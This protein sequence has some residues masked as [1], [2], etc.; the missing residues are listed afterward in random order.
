MKSS[1]KLGIAIFCAIA[2]LSFSFYPGSVQ[3]EGGGEPEAPSIFEHTMSSD[4]WNNHDGTYT[5]TLYSGPMNYESEQ[6][7]VPINTTVTQLEEL[8]F[9]ET[10]YFN[11]D[12][13]IYKAYFKEKSGSTAPNTKPVR[14]VYE[15]YTI[16]FAP[17]S[18]KFEGQ[19]SS[20]L[21][22]SLGEIGED[23]QVVYPSQFDT[24]IDL[25]YRYWN[26][27]LKEQLVINS[28]QDIYNN[29]KSDPNPEDNLILKFIIRAYDLSDD[30]DM[31]MRIGNNH[32]DFT[33]DYTTTDQ[34]AINFLDKNNRTIYRM[35]IPYAIDADGNELL[36]DYNIDI[37]RF[38]NLKVSILTPFSWLENAVYPVV[39]DPTVK[40]QDADTENLEDASVFSDSPDLPAGSEA[41]LFIHDK[42][43][44]TY[45][46][47]MM[48]NISFLPPFTTILHANI[49]L[50]RHSESNHTNENV[51]IYN[52]YNWTNGDRGHD[53][54][55]E[56][57][58]TWNNQ[59]CGTNFD[60]STYCNLTV[61]S[62]NSI[63]AYWNTW[64]ITQMVK[65]THKDGN[66][67]VSMIFRAP[68]VDV[69]GVGRVYFSKEYEVDISLRPFLNITY[70]VFIITILPVGSATYTT[71]P[72]YFNITNTTAVNNCKADIDGGN[73]SMTWDATDN[74]FW[75]HTNNTILDGSHTVKFWCN[76]TGVAGEQWYESETISF[77]TNMPEPAFLGHIRNP[78]PPKFNESSLLNVTVSVASN[79]SVWI[80]VMGVQNYSL[81][82]VH[83]NT[84]GTEW[85]FN[86]SYGNLTSHNVIGYK[87][88]ANDTHGNIN[89]TQ[90]YTFTVGNYLPSI[91]IFSYPVDH[92]HTSNTSVT[93]R[94]SASTDG[95]VGDTVTYYGFIN[96]SASESSTYNFST[97]GTQIQIDGFDDGDYNI[98]IWSFDAYDNSTANTTIYFTIDTTPPVLSAEAINDTW[99]NGTKSIELTFT[100]TDANPWYCWGQFTEEDDTGFNISGSIAGTTCTVESALVD[101]LGDFNILSWA[102]DT[103]GSNHSGTL[104]AGVSV[105]ISLG[106]DWWQNNETETSLVNG[107][108]HVTMN[109]T[110]DNSMSD[111]A[112]TGVTITTIPDRSADW[113]CSKITDVDVGAREHSIQEWA[114]NCTTERIGTHYVVEAQETITNLTIISNQDVNWTFFQNWTIFDTDVCYTNL[115]QNVT[116]Y[117][118]HSVEACY[119]NN[120][121]VFDD[122]CQI[123]GN[124]VN[125]TSNLT[126]CFGG[127]MNITVNFTSP[128][129]QKTQGTPAQFAAEQN[130]TVLF[131]R[132]DTYE[133]LAPINLTSVIMNITVPKD[134]HLHELSIT[135]EDGAETITGWHIQDGFVL[136]TQSHINGSGLANNIIEITLSYNVTAPIAQL[137]NLTVGTTST[138]SF[139][140]TSNTSSLT[141]VYA[142]FD[143]SEDL[144]SFNLWSN[145]TGSWTDITG[146]PAYSYNTHDEDGDGKTDKVS[147]YIPSMSTRYY[148]LNGSLGE[149]IN[150]TET[151]VIVNSP[152]SQY[153][154]VR[155]RNVILIE[156]NNPIS[157][158]FLYKIRPPSDA[159][160]FVLDGISEEPLWDASGLYIS[161]SG[162]LA[163][164]SNET[165]NLTYITPSVT[166]TEDRVLPDVYIVDERAQISINVSIKN[167]V[168]EDLNDTVEKSVFIDYGEDVFLCENFTLPCNSSNAIDEANLI[169]G[170]FK[171][172]LSSIEADEIKRYTVSYLIPTA[173][174]EIGN[175]YREVINGTVGII[176]PITI[177]SNAPISM[178]E[179]EAEIEEIDHTTVSKIVDDVT[180][181]LYHFRGGSTIIELGAMDTAS[182]ISLKVYAWEPGLAPVILPEVPFDET[183]WG[184][185]LFQIFGK[186]IR[187]WHIFLAGG[188]IALIIIAI[189]F[190]FRKQI[191]GLRKDG[192]YRN[193][194]H[195]KV[196][197]NKHI[198]APME[199]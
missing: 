24:G 178:R 196:Q 54:L 9:G 110:L 38:G 11:V 105:N 2:V 166:T 140:V 179:V 154:N 12:R 22:R 156:N 101:Q 114:I 40:L 113:T 147:F 25:T 171:I 60:N 169:S 62:N 7:F 57:V 69:F 31:D 135:G 6:G 184:L 17:Q 155:W 109:V 51:S 149:E 112:V 193:Y 125:V 133:N 190:D 64:S 137:S 124:E 165:H 21:K 153:T 88:W 126:F 151:K 16:T 32:L 111:T 130:K 3:G 59:P 132:S 76:K 30:T 41:V 82:D 198:V 89:S 142:Y 94:W 161:I 120:V 157:Q 103:A 53:L 87:W 97:T 108:V 152:I 93:F 181:E 36:L 42:S 75:N 55:N 159:R 106:E 39:I 127:V 143:I 191:G 194:N 43:V 81:S 23:N 8:L 14:L 136:F 164:D 48:F 121:R 197:S 71:S 174:M 175:S 146:S 95:D 85:Y 65:D 37:T 177:K 119:V 46:I 19:T 99:F 35:P 187:V 15:N 5:T 29:I 189:K 34:V 167:W 33:E 144:I 61:E 122:Y 74:A 118:Q 79:D 67:N 100:V 86:L 56:S 18:L 104:K 158:S 188:I 150:V 116:I 58:L 115:T 134:V 139:N 44:A 195:C 45:Q 102:N 160:N 129:L 72:I 73:I 98:S 4:T 13:G 1:A 84:G 47:Y 107:T 66:E 192:N 26:D 185:P 172:E 20:H 117:G 70:S 145:D 96:N 77:T 83:R 182:T 50:Y 183:F 68:T 138:Y 170:M 162:T 80:E 78:D 148:I 199:E 91:P 90:N 168:S 186:N 131:T 163:R 52:V 123:T 63:S 49:S 180:G 176:F 28:L 128:A 92:N 10:Y 27:R 173:T 141:D